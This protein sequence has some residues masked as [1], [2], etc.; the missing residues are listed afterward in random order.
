LEGEQRG[1]T[2]SSHRVPPLWA[3]FLPRQ[4]NSRA[5]F[6]GRFGRIFQPKISS[7]GLPKNAAKSAILNPSSPIINSR[8]P[9]TKNKAE[10]P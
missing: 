6:L 10:I 9:R 8:V 1:D 5:G 3:A 7:F 4:M 2:E